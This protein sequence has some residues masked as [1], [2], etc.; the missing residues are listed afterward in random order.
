MSLYAGVAWLTVFVTTSPVKKAS[1]V[2][3]LHHGANRLSVGQNTDS[4]VLGL[5]A[6]AKAVP[7]AAESVMRRLKEWVMTVPTSCGIRGQ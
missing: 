6:G 5:V 1:V 2:G 3:G 7:A 4:N